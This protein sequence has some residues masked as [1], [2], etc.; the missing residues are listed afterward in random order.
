MKKWLLIALV[1][2]VFL[3]S[4]SVSPSYGAATPKDLKP[5]VFGHDPMDQGRQLKEG[6]KFFALLEKTPIWS[7]GGKSRGEC[8]GQPGQSLAAKLMPDSDIVGKRKWQATWVY[9]CGNDI[10]NPAGYEIYFYDN[11]PKTEM[12][13][14]PAPQLVCGEG[15]HQEGAV[16]VPDKVVAPPSPPAQAPQV[17]LRANPLVIYRGQQATLDWDSRYADKLYFKDGGSAN[18]MGSA[19][20]V[21]NATTTYVLVASGPGGENSASVTV[22]VLDPTCQMKKSGW[23]SIIG[24]LIGGGLGILSRNPYI[25]LAAGTGGAL[26]GGYIDGGCITP[27]DAT[28]GIATGGAAMSATHIIYHPKTPG[29]QGPAGKDGVPGAKGDP[30]QSVTGP[31]GPPGPPGPPGT[32]IFPSPSPVVP[33][34]PVGPAVGPGI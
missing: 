28:T 3:S 30:G 33:P 23:G 24:G 5:C 2:A 22:T 9:D 34:V 17:K 12:P 11:E 16:C 15:T 4:F 1:L 31:Q 18:E 10:E 6:E 7:R 8:M 13:P 20:T 27:S 29:P 14:K 21:P 25:A 26:I 32:V 19:V